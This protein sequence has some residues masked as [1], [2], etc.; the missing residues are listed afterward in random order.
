[1][2]NAENEFESLQQMEHSQKLFEL[3]QIKCPHS[4]LNQYLEEMKSDSFQIACDSYNAESDR[5]TSA[6]ICIGSS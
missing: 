3:L 1:M 2:K 5:K 4:Q 6:K